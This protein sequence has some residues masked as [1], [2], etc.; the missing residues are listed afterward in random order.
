MNI[1]YVSAMWV[2]ALLAPSWTPVAWVSFTVAWGLAKA[3]ADTMPP[4]GVSFGVSCRR[5][6]GGEG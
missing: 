4:K 1:I 5:G 3:A 6:A 2:V